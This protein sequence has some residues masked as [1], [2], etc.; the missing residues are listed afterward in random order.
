[1]NTYFI[2]MM[3]TLFAQILDLL[4]VRYTSSFT[5]TYYETHPHKQDLF[6]L[7]EMLRHYGVDNSALQLPQTAEHLCA[8]DTPFVAYVDQEFVLVRSV[9]SERVAYT[10][11]GKAITLSIGDF[12]AHWSGVVLLFEA[13][14]ESGEPD[15]WA[16]RKAWM[17]RW[18]VSALLSAAGLLLCVMAPGW[19][20][21]GGQSFLFLLL[22]GIGLSFS[23][24]LLSREWTGDGRYV[25]KVCSLFLKSSDCDQVLDTS[26]SRFMGV[27]WSVVGTGFFMSG[28]LLLLFF[29]SGRL[30]VGLMPIIALPYTLWSLWYQAS[31]VR[32]WCV[33]CVAVQLLVWCMAGFSVLIQGL[34]LS[35][36][37]WQAGLFVGAAYLWVIGLLHLYVSEYGE[38]RRLSKQVNKLESVRLHESVFTA[39]ASES[40][41]YPVDKSIGLLLGNPDAKRWITLVS[42]PH[43]APC[44]RLHPQVDALLRQEAST[45]C[46]QLILTSFGEELEPSAMLLISMYRRQDAPT[47]LRFMA[48]WYLEG[49]HQK[50][51]YYQLYG[52]DS[53][54]KAVLADLEAMKRWAHQNKISKTPTI[55]LDGVALPD[56][57]EFK[58]LTY[59]IHQ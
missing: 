57:Y 47:F 41:R 5:D 54:D 35:V 53:E 28:I 23:L 38:A 8:L 16:H 45:C 21:L 2:S 1:M 7:S 26:A 25:R 22:H 52:L 44:A 58:D 18:I 12:L 9:S 15:Y 3:K 13:T 34:D 40:V 17:M 4:S 59:F 19:G 56:A 49:R 48:D 37:R 42:N 20:S 33:L 39:L 51:H 24:V 50:E 10:W 31:Q 6:G 43:C 14:A 46:V 11:Q 32:Q 55:L 27:S 30:Y 29:P 36:F